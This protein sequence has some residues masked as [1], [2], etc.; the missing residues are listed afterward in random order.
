MKNFSSFNISLL[1]SKILL[2][3][4]RVSCLYLLL[5][6]IA[7]I[8]YATENDKNHFQDFKNIP[9]AYGHVQLQDSAGHSSL[10]FRAT[11]YDS[12]AVTHLEGPY[13]DSA[14]HIDNEAVFRLN[15]Y[16]NLG[17]RFR[18]NGMIQV[19]NDKTNRR[20][21]P[22]HFY[23]P[24]DGYPYNRQSSSTRTWDIFKLSLDYDLDFGKLLAGIDYLKIGVAKRNPLILRGAVSH[25][26]PWQDSSYRLQIPTPV[27]YFGFSFNIGFLTYS[28][29]AAKLYHDKD[30]G[31][32]MHAHRL[33]AA[34]PAKITI[35]VSEVVL[36]GS[37]VEPA[38]SNP[39]LDS[40]STG[41]D[42]EWSYVVPFIPY[43]FEEHFLGD[44]DNNALA[45]D[46]RVQTLRRWEFYGEL[47][48]DDMKNPT[49]M[50]DDSWWGNKWAASIGFE[51]IQRIQTFEIIWNAEYT[52]I[53]PW[54]YTHHKGAGYTYTSYGQ[55][56]GSDLG[57]NAEE[58]YTS[59][60]L[61]W[62][63]CSA[64]LFVSAVS[65]DTAFGSHIADIHTPTSA[66]DKKFLNENTTFNYLELGTELYTA[67]FHWFWLRA[68]G[69]LFL[70]D[71]EGYRIEASGGLSW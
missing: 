43:A 50:L 40:D 12:L 15:Y 24:Y 7:S 8:S 22:P 4:I 9:T 35:G 32:Y 28:Q 67:P 53:E 55:N 23:D 21:I 57:P 65:K 25:F 29:Y 14:R 17:N 64:L 38:G 60:T 11:I 66:T 46:V 56:L 49:D 33:E 16:G 41:R 54:V 18:F 63:K 70:G 10:N 27:P 48:W 1:H 42:F 45:F 62:K 58:I 44:K 19:A 30:L 51:T 13:G 39:N 69:S 5:I 37:T 26:R 34:L 6:F 52:R 59:L 68:R 3:K 36:Y 31:K 71:Y 2:S 61:N 20:D 47:L